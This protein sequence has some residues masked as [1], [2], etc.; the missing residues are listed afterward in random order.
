MAGLENEDDFLMKASFLS[1]LASGSACRSVYPGMALW[2]ANSDYE[3][4]SDLYAVPYAINNVFQS[5]KDTILIVSAEEKAVSSSLGHKMM[6]DNL[7][8][9]VRYKQANDNLG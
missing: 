4:G 8:A 7:Y 6:H 2:G 1:R 5:F 9:D 3:K